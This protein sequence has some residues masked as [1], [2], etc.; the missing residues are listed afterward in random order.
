MKTKNWTAINYNGGR[1]VTIK[2]GS[3]KIATVHYGD[4]SL[5]ET[6]N[7]AQLIANAPQTK[8]ER[9][10]LLEA[11]KEAYFDLDIRKRMKEK[12]TAKQ[13]TIMD[14]LNKRINNCK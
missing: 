5:K 13:L 9:D 4:T 7:N 3:N 11:C 2:E 1:E 8:R 10:E 14:N 12:L 6:A